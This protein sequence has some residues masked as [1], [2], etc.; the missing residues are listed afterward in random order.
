MHGHLP[1]NLPRN[2]KLIA[3]HFNETLPRFIAALSAAEEGLPKMVQWVHLD[4]DTYES[5]R[6]VL[7]ALTRFV[8]SGTILVFDDMLN[9]PGYKLGSLR[10]LFE[11][12]RETCW[13][14]R[15]LVAPWLV[16]W[17]WGEEATSY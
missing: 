7:F 11:F 16:D 15:V 1:Q 10:V 2:T 5:H 3:G 6:E 9:Y 4:C 12:Q 13:S 17:A 8:S 14:F